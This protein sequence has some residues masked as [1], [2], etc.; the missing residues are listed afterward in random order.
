MFYMGGTLFM[1]ILTI[2]LSLMIMYTILQAYRLIRA[3][4]DDL[5][6]IKSGMVHIKSI[7][8]FALVSGIFGQL[9]GVYEAFQAIEKA[10][11][12]SPAMIFGGIKVSM[13][14]PLYGLFIYLLGLLMYII[15]DLITNRKMNPS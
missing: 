10:G 9:I 4:R 1:S 14:A 5:P 6:R 2:V 3:E 11:D 7:G 15:M 8:F 13:I 12:I